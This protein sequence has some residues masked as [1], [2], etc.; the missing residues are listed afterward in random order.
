MPARRWQV[1]FYY[2]TALAVYLGVVAVLDSR[3]YYP[4][5]LLSV[6]PRL[7]VECLLFVVFLQAVLLSVVAPLIN[8]RL[9]WLARRGG[10]SFIALALCDMAATFLLYLALLVAC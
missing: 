5:N 3:S 2:H 1:Y 10:P 4:E 6:G 8:L 7:A 9:L